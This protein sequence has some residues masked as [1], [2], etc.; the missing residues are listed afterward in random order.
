MN[1]S[2]STAVDRFDPPKVNAMIVCVCEGLSDREIAQTI[3]AGANTLNELGHRCRAGI[4]CGRCREMLRGMLGDR[5]RSHARTA[6]TGAA[7]QT[8]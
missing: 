5:C 3:Q 7:S 4:D 6:D 2:S 1:I 8:T